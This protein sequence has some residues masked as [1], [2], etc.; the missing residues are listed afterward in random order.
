MA[1]L[2]LCGLKRPQD[3]E[4]VNRYSPDY[5][6]FVFAKSCR[7]VTPEQAA[8]LRRLLKP[9][10][11]P[12]GVFV[13]AKIE[14]ITALVEERVIDAVQLHGDET[15]DYVETLQQRLERITGINR[16]K[17]I[18]KTEP[19]RRGTVIKAIR[20]SSPQEVK[21]ALAYP[22]A[23]LLFDTYTQGQYGG[24]GKGFDW[25]LLKKVDR[26]FFLAGGLK[27][28]NV[29]KAIKEVRPFCVDISS[30]AETDGVKD[31][32]KIRRLVEIIM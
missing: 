6:G 28:D 2:K 19:V 16:M 25:Q 1:K 15:I 14:A 31:K 29:E 17:A 11:L 21:K 30:G 12:I 22:T 5:V 27:A 3:I 23:Y 26:P 7:Q 10:I 13:N 20:V 8:G 9:E 32:E 24:S 4:F 18:R